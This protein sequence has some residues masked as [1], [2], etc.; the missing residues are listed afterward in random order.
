MNYVLAHLIGDYIL[1]NDWMAINKK[2]SN[3]ACFVHVVTYMIPFLFTGIVW[4]LLII[5]AVEHYIQDR[6]NI[7]KWFM[8]KKGSDKFATDMWG[9]IVTDNI[10]HILFIASVLALTSQ[11]Q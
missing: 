7:V 10:L 6:T 1:Q 5:I 3:F 11:S 4:W 9:V 8:I 2:K